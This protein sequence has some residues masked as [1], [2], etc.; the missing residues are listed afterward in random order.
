MS[1]GDFIRRFLIGAYITYLATIPIIGTLI[2]DYQYAQKIDMGGMFA[3]ATF[4]LVILIIVHL[5]FATKNLMFPKSIF[6]T[7]IFVIKVPV[8]AVLYLF[9]L[10][11]PARLFLPGLYVFEILG[12]W[13]AILILIFTS[14]QVP[15]MKHRVASL[16]MAL[17]MLYFTFY[18]F[19]WMFYELLE[20]HDNLWIGLGSLLFPIV[21]VTPNYIMNM[22][23]K[24]KDAKRNIVYLGVE[25]EKQQKWTLPNGVGI[26][27]I[28]VL[29]IS[30]W[31][32]LILL[33]EYY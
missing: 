6:F 5:V 11:I 4:V 10:D 3:L 12:L 2:Y 25:M 24:N 13:T 27:Y 33:Q 29:I 8:A 21:V 14:S 26:V 20:F 15:S 22:N 17:P 18:R 31:G 28:F 9:L 16:V 19:E 32:S 1:W 23:D 30:M 7:F